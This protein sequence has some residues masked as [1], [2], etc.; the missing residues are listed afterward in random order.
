M[1]KPYLNQTQRLSVYYNTTGGNL[2][3]LNIALK[4]LGREII[5]IFK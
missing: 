2:L 4:K 1:K 5:K 3:L